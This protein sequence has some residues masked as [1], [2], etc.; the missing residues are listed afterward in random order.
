MR[1]SLGKVLLLGV[2]ELRSLRADPVLLPLILYAFSFAVYSAAEDAAID[3]RNAAVAIV[4]EDRSTLSRRLSAAL[5]PPWFQQPETIAFDEVDPALETGRYTFVLD[6]PPDFERDV[7]AG[8]Q[9]TLRLDIDATAMSVAGRGASYIQT[10][11]QREV[12]RFLGDEAPGDAGDPVRTVIRVRFNPNLRSEWF[13]GVIEVVNNITILAIILAGAAVIRERE[14][15]TLEHLLVMPVRPSEI[16]LAKVWAN[17]LV[18]LVAALTSLVVI[19]R[20]LIGV[21]IAGS[22][23]LFAAGTGLYLFSVTALGIFLAT[24]AR[25]M[26][27]FGLLAIPAFIVMILLSGS[28]TPLESMPTFLQWLMLGSP[29]TWYTEFAKSVLSRGADIRVVWPELAGVFVTGAVYFAAA[30][31]RFRASVATA[32]G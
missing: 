12:A 2:K 16:M 3:V 20:G 15:G 6:V 8:E 22:L 21:P 23:S 25:S 18:I 13:Q 30:L 10:I 29:S 5:A 32:R 28:Y 27:Q 31:V 17:G 7:L 14:H 24:L 9:P 11:V 19:V 4:D 26:P 1:G